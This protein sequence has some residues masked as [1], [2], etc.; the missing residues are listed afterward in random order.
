[1]LF[2]ILYYTLFLFELFYWIFIILSFLF[3]SLTVVCVIDPTPGASSTSE[4]PKSLAKTGILPAGGAISTPNPIVQRLP[5]FL[6]NHNYAK[7]PLQVKFRV[8]CVCT[9]GFG[10][11]GGWIPEVYVCVGRSRR[12]WLQELAVPGG[13]RPHS[14]VTLMMMKIMRMKRRRSAKFRILPAGGFVWYCSPE[15]W[16]GLGYIPN[17]GP[18]TGFRRR[19]GSD[20][21]P[22]PDLR[23]WAEPQWSRARQK[24]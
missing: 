18:P 17:T 13:P 12:T 11:L 10:S 15:R 14:L 22:R 20:H 21:R 16:L 23:W 5:A 7:S 4:K 1:M 19:Q 24:T 9:L 2:L 8:W 3:F 6:D